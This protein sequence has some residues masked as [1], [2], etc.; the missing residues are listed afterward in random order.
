MLRWL[1]GS[2]PPGSLTLGLLF[3]YNVSLLMG[4]PLWLPQI[5]ILHAMWETWVP[6]LGP[7][8]PLEKEMATH[9][10][11]PAWKIHGWRNLVGYSPWGCKE[12]DTTERLHFHIFLVCLDDLAID[13]SGRLKS[14]TITVL[15]STPPV[16][17]NICQ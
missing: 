15:L 13:V 7:E 11:I 6:S 2:L 17:L 12:S 16:S 10:S 8:N 5:K 1:A 9:S 14:D 3:N 4:L